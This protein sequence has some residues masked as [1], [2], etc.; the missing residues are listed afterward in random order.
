M[1]KRQLQSI[2]LVLTCL[3]SGLSLAQDDDLRNDPGFYDFGDVPG[4]SGDPKVEIDL[5]P[6]MLGMVASAAAEKDSE[7]SDILSGLRGIKVYVYEHVESP[8]QVRGFID[9]VSGVLEDQAWMRM[10]Y[11]NSEDSK[12]RI[13][14]RPD[15]ASIAGMTIMVSSDDD[16]AVFINVVGSINPSELGRIAGNIGVGNLIDDLGEA[17][18]D[19][20]LQ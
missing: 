10:V 4:I 15:G 11:I 7:V 2:V 3:F 5:N 9:E 8:D 16:E 13:H 20:Q 14:V 12:V 18:S 17:V 19:A 6:L 1:L